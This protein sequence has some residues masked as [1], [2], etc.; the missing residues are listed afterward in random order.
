MSTSLSRRALKL[1]RRSIAH[2]DLFPIDWMNKLVDVEEQWGIISNDFLV[3]AILPHSTFSTSSRIGLINWSS[4][5]DSLG[6][7]SEVKHRWL[8]IVQ[9][10][11][12]IVAYF[13]SNQINKHNRISEIN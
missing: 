7:G 4:V 8:G 5:N 12:S 13:Y 2:A 11:L 1:A 10:V 3:L 9:W 6:D